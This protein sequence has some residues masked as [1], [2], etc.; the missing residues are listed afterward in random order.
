M[1]AILSAATILL[2]CSSAIAQQDHADERAI[3]LQL[4]DQY[5]KAVS[6]GNADLVASHIAE[7]F[8]GVMTTN[9]SVT[10]LAGLKDYWKRI[11]ELI[12]SGGTVSTKIAYE[13]T[14]FAGDL[15]LSHGTSTNQVKTSAGKTYQY[16]TH[17]TAISR[18]SGQEWKLLR[19]HDSMDPINNEFVEAFSS[20]RAL[21]YSAISGV[22]ALV[23]G[24][25]VGRITKQPAK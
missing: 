17:W 13:P 4:K 23:L 24:V 1:K 20:Y 8:T 11:Q 25:F 6:E 19:I 18:K 16:N 12:G 14:L 21:K 9:E 3:L 10:G 15:A 5:E 7:S 22:L 2:L